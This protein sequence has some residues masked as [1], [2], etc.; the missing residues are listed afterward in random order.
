[1]TSYTDQITEPRNDRSRKHLGI[2]YIKLGVKIVRYSMLHAQNWLETK[3]VTLEKR[4]HRGRPPKAVE[5]ARERDRQSVG[6]K[7]QS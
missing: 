7:D 5:V 1:M 6:D 3:K 4:P 2:P